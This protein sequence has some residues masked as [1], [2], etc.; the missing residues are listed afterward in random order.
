MNRRVAPVLLLM[1]LAAGSAWSACPPTAEDGR[2]LSAG[3]VRLAWRVDGAP[4]A[5][6][7][8]FALLLRVCPADARLLKVDA[9]MPEHR[10]GMNYRPSLTALGDGRWRADGL[11][12]HMAG[13]WEL[14]FEA[15][16]G[17]RRERLVD[18]VALK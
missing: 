14:S 4:I 15:E 16:A 3:D 11:L 13:R 8:H 10:H 17:G 18:S 12:F 9:G 1:G 5:N 6:G 7:R 2:L